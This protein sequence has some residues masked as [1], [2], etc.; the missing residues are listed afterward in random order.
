M[1]HRPMFTLLT[2]FTL[3]APVTAQRA[4]TGAERNTILL[5][6]VD[7]H[8]ATPGAARRSL[9]R[10][11]RAALEV[12]GA[13]DSSLRELKDAIH[14]SACWREAMAGAVAQ[15]DDPMLSAAYADHPAGV[16]HRD[17]GG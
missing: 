2:L 16:V 5:R 9:A 4:E 6:H 13:F 7:R 11:D 10:I 17:S 8:P 1:T 15:I 14:R 12:C 3:V